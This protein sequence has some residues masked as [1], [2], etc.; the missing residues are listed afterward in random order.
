MIA[1]Q[2]AL[3]LGVKTVSIPWEGQSLRG[4]TRM[5]MR[6]SSQRERRP[7]AVDPNQYDLFEVAARGENRRQCFSYA[8]APLLVPLRQEGR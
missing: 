6:L 8:G 4:L 1:V 3:A 5:G 2:Y 7:H